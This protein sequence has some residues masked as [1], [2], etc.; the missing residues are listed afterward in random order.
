MDTAKTPTRFT[1][2]NACFMI[3]SCFGTMSGNSIDNPVT[4]AARSR[5]AG[6]VSDAD[7]VGMPPEHDRDRA[8]RLSGGLDLR[9]RRRKND[10]DLQAHEGL[11]ELWQPFRRLRPSKDEVDVLALDIAVMQQAC[12]QGVYPASRLFCGRTITEVSDPVD[13]RGRLS[14]GA[15][16]RANHTRGKRHEERSPVDHWIT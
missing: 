3:S 8:G 6:H 14:G 9:R 5:K 1:C 13:L 4:I 12:P 7:G 15:E 2:G 16:R 11:P 10:I